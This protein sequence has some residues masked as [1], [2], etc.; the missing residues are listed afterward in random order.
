MYTSRTIVCQ[1][2]ELVLQGSQTQ[3]LATAPTGETPATILQQSNEG[4]SE[5]RQ[6]QLRQLATSLFLI[7]ILIKFNA[8]IAP[9]AKR[10]VKEPLS[11]TEPF[12][13]VDVRSLERRKIIYNRDLFFFLL[14]HDKEVR[15][16]KLQAGETADLIVVAS[17]EMQTGRLRSQVVPLK[18][19]I[20]GKLGETNLSCAVTTNC[21]P[22]RGDR[23]PG[24]RSLWP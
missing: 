19:P 1:R 20:V 3:R 8:Y 10:A 24:P 6:L 13:F 9:S 15:A 12:L 11:R 7:R 21:W 2:Y 16:R 18:L 5:S 23:I 17:K 4:T 14:F 22:R